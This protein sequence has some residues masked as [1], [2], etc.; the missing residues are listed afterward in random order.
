MKKKFIKFTKFAILFL[1]INTAAQTGTPGISGAADKVTGYGMKDDGSIWNGIFDTPKNLY[2]IDKPTSVY[3]SIDDQ[4][5]A[6]FLDPQ[7]V[8]VIEQKDN[9]L[10][11]DTWMGEKWIKIN[12]IRNSVLLD[13][14]LLNQRDL[15]YPTG[16]EIVSLGMMINYQTKADIHTLISQMPLSD[17]PN[18][19]FVGNPAVMSGFTVF[20]SALTPLAEEY[21]GQ[22]VDMTGCGIYDLKAQLNLN[23]PIV[24]WV[25]GLGFNVHAICLTGYNEEGFY[26]NDPWKGSK[27]AF[28]SYDYFYSIWNKPI[29]G[30]SFTDSNGLRKALSICSQ[31]GSYN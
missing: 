6:D 10:L 22:A 5:S 8:T 28:I 7:V 1:M 4:I 20:P 31:Y 24:V 25:S 3:N 12:S 9:W 21:L 23:C 11:I 14:P 19:G 15:G 2:Y 13:V 29:S 17:D 26:Y 16:C 27:N 18:Y 30:G